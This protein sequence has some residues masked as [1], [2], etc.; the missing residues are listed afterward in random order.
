MRTFHAAALRGRYYESVD[1]GSKDFV[2]ESEGTEVFIAEFDGLLRTCVRAAEKTTRAPVREA[3]E[4][5][6]GLLRHIDECRDDAIFFA[7]EARSWQVGADWRTALHA[8]FRC[9]ARAPRRRSSRARSI[10]RSPTSRIPSG[11]AT[12]QRIS[13]PAAP[14]RRRRCGARWHADDNRDLRVVPSFRAGG[15]GSSLGP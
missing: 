6:F 8:Y 4:L 2:K 12:W 5:L 14:S 15:L 1:V 13:A 9:L 7:D 11:H 10:G 3:F